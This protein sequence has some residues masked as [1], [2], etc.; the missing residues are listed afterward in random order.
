MRLWV[1]PD[2]LAKLG[3]TVTDI[4]NAVQAQNT[5]NPAGQVGG[6]PAPSDQQFTYAVL[7]QGRLTSPEQ[8]G[9]VIVRETPNGGTVRVK[10]VARIELGTQDYSMVCRL[11][12]KQRR[13]RC[14]LSAARN[15][16]SS[17]S[18]GCPEADGA[19]EAAIPGRRGLRHI[20]RPDGRGDGRHEG[21]C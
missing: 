6:E 4:A 17:N 9:N 12:G 15:Q 11:N 13:D 3:I 18:G 21:D 7:A 1:N 5:V 14:R 2:Q 10:D 20:A 19:D 8:F 16:R